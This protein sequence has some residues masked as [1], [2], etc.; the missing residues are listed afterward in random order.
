MMAPARVTLED[1]AQ[2]AGVSTAAVSQALSGKGALS[3]ATR[4]R[5]LQVVEELS[6]QPD[7]VAQSQPGRR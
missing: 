4:E 1:I 5:I 2:R 3:Q 6:Y 7:K